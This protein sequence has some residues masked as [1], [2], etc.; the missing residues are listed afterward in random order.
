MPSLRGFQSSQHVAR[1]VRAPRLTIPPTAAN[2]IAVSRL[3]KL[4]A[5]LLATLWLPAALHCQLEGADIHFLTH[6]IAHNDSADHDHGTGPDD[7]HH[8]FKDTPVT[9]SKP[10]MKLLLPAQ[11]QSLV[12]LACLV[13]TWDNPTLV[14]SPARHAPPPEL[15]VAW[16]FVRRAAPPAR[17][18]NRA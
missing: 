13:T 3:M 5:L 16:Q 6:D 4:A 12:L 1:G 10:V 11:A 8:A 7:G 2:R 14:L 15:M 9:A 17:A 18:P